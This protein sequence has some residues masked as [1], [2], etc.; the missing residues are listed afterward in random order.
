MEGNSFNGLAFKV[1]F[2]LVISEI[3]SY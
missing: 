1:L 2:G 3:R